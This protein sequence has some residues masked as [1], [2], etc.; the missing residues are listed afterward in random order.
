MDRVRARRWGL[1]ALTL[2]LAHPTPIPAIPNPGPLRF[3]APSPAA[4]SVASTSTISVQL[5]AACTLDPAT[6]AVSLNGSAIPAAQFLPF[7]AC[8]AN[9]ITSQAVV[10]ALALPDGTISGGP[11]SINAG[12]V[13]AFSGSGT[14]DALAWNFDG[15]AAPAS[16]SPV[17]P[18][19]TAAGT[20]T[21]R[22]QATKA[23]SLAASGMDGGNLVTAQD[24]FKAGD[25][26]PDTRQLAVVMP[27]DVDFV[28]YEV[29]H[30]HPLALSAAGDRLYAVNTPEARLAIFTVAALDGSLTYAG[31]VPVGLDPV[32]LAVRPGTNE[33]WVANHLSDTVSVVDV[34]ARKLLAT[35]A[36]GDEPN[37]VAF[38]SG[39]AFVTCGGNEDRVKVYNATSRALITSIDLFG[40]EPRALAVNAAG[41]EVY[42]VLLESGNKTTTLFSALVTSGGG[43]PAPSPS[44]NPALG[45]A[46]ATGLIVKFNGTNWVDESGK[47]WSSSV[48]YT[49]PDN[50]VSVINATAATPSVIR[51]VSGVGTILFDAVTNPATGSL[52]VP[53]TEAR[54]QTR[55]EPNLRGHLVQTRVSM[56]DTT[57]G[58]V[59]PVD[60]NSHINYGVTPGTP[61]E[62]ALSLSQPGAGVFKSDGSKFYLTAFGSRKVGV[63]NAAG[64]V[65]ARIDVG[66]GPSGVALNETANRLYV[67]N[68]FDNTVSTVDTTS[69][70]QLTVTGVTGASAFDPSPD[71]IKTGR[72]FLYDAQLTSGHGDIACATCHVSSNFDDIAWDLG[73]PQGSFVP[74]SSAPF[75]HFFLLGGSTT[76]FDPMKGPMTTQTLRGLKNLSPFHWRGDRENFQAFNPA[77]VNL[78][79]TGGQLSGSDMDAY[80]A[81]IET[82][83]FPPNPFRNL[84]DTMPLSMQV[85]NQTGV[86]T[87]AADPNAGSNDFINL[88][89][90]AGVLA[91]NTC[92]TL[93]TGA[94]RQLFN[95]AQEGESQDF[96][97][98]QLRN[99]YEKVGFNPVRPNIQSGNPNL[100]AG[101]AAPMKRGFGFLHDGSVSLTEFLAAPVFQSTTQQERDLFAFLLAFATDSSAA[102]GKQI[103]VDS[104]T[105]GDP[106]IATTIGTLLAQANA[107]KCDVVGKAVIGGVAK[108]YFYDKTTA[109]LLP[110][111]LLEQPISESALRGSLA[112]GDVLTYTGVPPGAGVR[113]GIDRDRDGFL[114]RTETTLGFDPANPH[115]NPWQF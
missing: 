40:D 82:V 7:S 28:N 9:R 6:L 113:L 19:F 39:R 20:F 108:G 101:Q 83:R 38:A 63:L 96:K 70:T 24:A 87:A 55:F 74:Y 81:F 41:T 104:T 72:K 12:A 107:S 17:S 22:L 2:L 21:V 90:D 79:G 75:V 49:L 18:T 94:D 8:N 25:A 36:V 69:N 48:K 91:C 71:V 5:D 15:G 100:I 114:D 106:T 98:P 99:M 1:V 57:G 59:S 76:G 42:A 50:D 44:R 61:A 13:A 80:T 111:S 102:V 95:G 23:A 35:I 45:T 103:T 37:D 88:Q 68:R 92:H 97:I 78:M 66:G 26:S 89:L 64:A 62:I 3:I 93:P 105:K 110:D 58:V 115:S 85:P 10:V 84:D 16:G 56:V 86:G 60:L 34:V 77:F 52:W 54:N 33:V 51:T 109:K 29:S 43:P 47:N 32:S 65:T 112:A 46:P 53:N 4:G 31:D 30:V 14:G 67:L 27:P 73:N 11:A